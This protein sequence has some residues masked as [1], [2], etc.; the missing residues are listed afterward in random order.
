MYVLLTLFAWVKPFAQIDYTDLTAVL[1]W[2]ALAGAPFLAGYVV[3]LLAENWPKW[4]TLPTPV[5]F[6][7]PLILSVLLALGANALLQQTEFVN[8][9]SPWWR[10]VA[11][12]ILTYLGTQQGYM[13]AK[14]SYY[15]TRAKTKAFN[16]N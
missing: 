14:R 1:G 7:T 9:I 8:A 12:S 11:A 15:G 2:V 5:K 6:Y 3:S 10:M 13:A 16:R 4:H